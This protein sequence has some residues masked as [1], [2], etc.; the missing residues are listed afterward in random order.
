MKNSENVF[1]VFKAC[2]HFTET[3]KKQEV[4]LDVLDTLL[5]EA[6]KRC[7]QYSVIQL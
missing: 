7:L 6:D 5:G 2:M 3:S 1:E 4:I